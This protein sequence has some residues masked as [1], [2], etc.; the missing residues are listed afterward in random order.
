MTLGADLT[1]LAQALE[2]M[3]FS[4]VSIHCNGDGLISKYLGGCM[5]AHLCRKSCLLVLLA[6]C[7]IVGKLFNLPEL[8]L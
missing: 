3:A 1:G 4:Q 6:C 5:C 2:P 8:H 7:E